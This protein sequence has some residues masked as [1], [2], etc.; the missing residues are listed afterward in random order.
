MNNR[1][2][3]R[4]VS[5]NYTPVTLPSL[6]AMRKVM[7]FVYLTYI[8]QQTCRV[9]QKILRAQ[10]NH[11]DRVSPEQSAIIKGHKIIKNNLPVMESPEKLSTSGIAG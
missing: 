4:R 6:T 10:R 5:I 11:E 7:V 1:T 3:C 8:K 2:L 9:A